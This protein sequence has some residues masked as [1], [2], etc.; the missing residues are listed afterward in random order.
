MRKIV[1]FL[2]MS[3]SVACS[4]SDSRKTP[5][6]LLTAHDWKYVSFVNLQQQTTLAPACEAD[7]TYTFKVDKTGSISNGASKCQP[8]DPDVKN[9]TWSFNNPDIRIGDLDGYMLELSDTKLTIRENLT[10][11]IYNYEKR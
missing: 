9:I 6:E 1:F 7:D 3:T 5:E 11:L 4:K 8:T 10:R 2:F